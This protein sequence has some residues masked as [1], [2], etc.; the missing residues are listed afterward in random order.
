MR[1]R[2]LVLALP[3]ATLA[4]SLAGALAACGSDGRDPVVP[5]VDTTSVPAPA[6]LAALG[7]GVVTTRYTAEVTTRAGYAY[8]STWGQRPTPG[9]AV[10]VWDV[11]GAAPVLVDSLLLD[12]VTTTG[13]VQVSDD[14]ALLAVATEPTGSLALYTLADPAHPRPLVRY[15]SPAI[16][17]GVHT[18]ELARVN[19][20]L[21]AFCS[22]DPRAGARARLVVLD[23]ST[24]GAP[25]EVL[26]REMGLPSVHDVFVRDGI[27]FTANWNDGLVVWDLGGGGLGGTVA[28]PV[29]LGRLRTVASRPASGPSVHNVWWFHDPSTGARRY[30]FV[31]EEVADGTTVGA[32]SAGDVHVVDVSDLTRPR[33]VAVYAVPGAGTHNFVVDEARGVLYAA[34]YNGGVRALDVRG[35]LSACPDAQR[36]GDGRCDLRRMGREIGVALDGTPTTPDP[37]SGQQLPPYVWGVALAGDRLY[38]SD[39]LGGL[40]VLG[41]LTR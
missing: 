22:I 16:A 9:N 21:H 24:P 33:E 27:L 12:G 14:G 6:R 26:V 19:G 29:E 1:A 41:A 5:P 34:Y 13:D 15:T 3:V 20:V 37:A 7:R 35:D 38:A 40:H 32:S 30:A 18:A 36:R 4:A 2:P 8:T 25:R 39:M 17:N 31:G 11:R 23:L 28:D 10:F